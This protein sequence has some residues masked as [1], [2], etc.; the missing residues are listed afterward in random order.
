MSKPTVIIVG[1][2]LSAFVLASKLYQQAE[3][4]IITKKSIHK[5]NSIRAQGGIA[6]AIAK[7]DHWR[8]HLMDTLQAGNYHNQPQAAEILVKQGQHLVKEL[9]KQGFPAD[10]NAEGSPL[11]GKEGAHSHRRI[12]H[13]GGDQTGKYL[14]HYFQSALIDK[15]NIIEEQSA[16]DCIVE[17][18]CCTGITTIDTNDHYHT[19]SAD[20]IVLATGGAG[21]IYETNTNDRTVTGDG[22]AIAYRAGASLTDLEF[23][24]FHPTMLVT[25]DTSNELVSEA[26]RGEGAVLVDQDGNRIMKGKHERLDLAPR[27]VVSRII[28]QALHERN[29][30]YLDISSVSDFR[31]KFPSISTACEKHNIE[32][33]SGKIPVKPGAH[34]TMGGV[35]TDLVGRTSITGLFAIGEVA[36]THVHGA[37][38]LASNSLLEGLVFATRLAEEILVP[39]SRKC[40]NVTKTIPLY[41]SVDMPSK[42]MIQDKMSR[43]VGINREGSSLKEMLNWLDGY[44]VLKDEQL[45]SY[46][47]TKEQC[48]IQHM[49]LTAQLIT[50]AAYERTES[51]GAHFRIDFPDAS[52]EW[53]QKYIRWNFHRQGVEI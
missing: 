23:I 7:Q 45:S 42:D 41:T 9:L 5:S 12:V 39:V 11:L 33:Q 43:H 22:I 31:Q 37:N 15:I 20:H 10:C 4:T 51:R 18:R 32:W 24:Q 26:V 8:W 38:R 27:D 50:K 30:I 17:E 53:K 40:S 2:G 35:E 21:G 1:A 19:Y 52:P 25:S 13:A 44:T 47:L 3:V 28:E 29:T 48:E 36:C 14:L 6:A 16:V 49:L 34:F 46:S